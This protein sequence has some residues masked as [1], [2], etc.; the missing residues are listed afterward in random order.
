M[1]SVDW[2]LQ[3]NYEPETL[4]EAGWDRQYQPPEVHTSLEDWCG[5]L[6]QAE[7]GV[8]IDTLLQAFE[9]AN[10]DTQ[11]KLPDYFQDDDG[12]FAPWLRQQL[13]DLL[14]WDLDAVFP[15]FATYL[16]GFS[17]FEMARFL[18]DLVEFLSDSPLVSD[19]VI[20]KL[21]QLARHLATY[22]DIPD[23]YDAFIETANAIEAG[24]TWAQD[25]LTHFKAEYKNAINGLE[26]EPGARTSSDMLQDLP[27]WGNSKFPSVAPLP[28][29]IEA[30]LAEDIEAQ[31]AED[32]EAQL[33]SRKDI[34]VLGAVLHSVF[35]GVDEEGFPLAHIPHEYAELFFATVGAAL[36]P[37]YNEVD[38]RDE[39]TA[40]LAGN[41]LNLDLVKWAILE[42]GL[43]VVN[44][45]VVNHT[46]EEASGHMLL[47]A[48]DM[49]KSTYTCMRHEAQNP[50]DVL[51]QAGLVELVDTLWDFA[52]SESNSLYR[53]HLQEDRIL[54]KLFST[55]GFNDKTQLSP[56]VK[57]TILE[58]LP[59]YSALTRISDLGKFSSDEWVAGARYLGTT[60]KMAFKRP[61]RFAVLFLGRIP[62]SRKDFWES[63]LPHFNPNYSKAETGEA[64]D[65]DGAEAVDDLSGDDLSGDD[66]S[67]IDFTGVDLKLT[68]VEIADRPIGRRPLTRDELIEYC[69]T[70]DCAK[71]EELLRAQNIRVWIS[72]LADIELGRIQQA[73][74]ARVQIDKELGLR[75]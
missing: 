67:G 14:I 66:L 39:L 75:V 43:T 16:E 51:F 12:D 7:A 32:I 60:S 9:T 25:V 48:V 64:L 29:D 2:N 71:A 35:A 33:A 13:T 23:E 56:S 54:K 37:D 19:D 8:S 44:S 21:L 28:E 20:D 61:D 62:A 73:I 24:P 70:G 27:R 72:G 57:L 5:I 22:A 11:R 41:N 52:L 17:T 46:N 58:H 63:L 47:A 6:K 45:V 30:Q 69:K 55:A 53:H 38:D 34:V 40:F 3:P 4:V 59:V 18:G 26:D 31:L 36:I 65:G 10:A 42:G 50:K 68:S 1:E 15:I 49:I 74:L